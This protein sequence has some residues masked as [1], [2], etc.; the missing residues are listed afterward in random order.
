MSD[1]RVKPSAR[2]QRL[3]ARA[4][5]RLPVWMQLRLS[6]QRQIVIDD[7]RLD[8]QVQ[9]L[10][11]IHRRRRSYGLCRPSPAPARARFRRDM[12]ATA[13]LK[14]YVGT[15]RDLVIACGGGRLE[16]RHYAPASAAANRD[17]LVYL[18]GGGFVLGDLDTHDEPCR[19]ICRHAGTHV[20]SIAYRLAPEHPFP[21]ALDDTLAA[22]SW[23]QENGAGLVGAGC[24]VSIGG[25]SAGGNLATVAAGLS[26]RSGS[27]PAAQLL[28]YPATDAHT[29]HPSKEM[30]G[31]GFFLDRKDCDDFFYYYTEGTGV[32]DD[33]PRVSPLRASDLSGLPAALV[34]TAGFDVL[35][36]E[37]DAYAAALSHAGTL[38]QLRR[39]PMLGHGFINMTGISRASLD[40]TIGVARA[41]RTMLDSLTA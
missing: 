28:I 30:F 1:A 39:I 40:A 13:P 29:V 33:D 19:I 34:V 35:R 5:G 25:D 10:L 41:W 2:V 38:T 27:A 11:A 37:G 3:A 17:L 26:T 24:R 23:A 22:L 36:D 31:D 15:V 9:L 12:L 6:G 8:P 32:S 18:H 4:L 14:T 16:A 7:Q 21:A 20:L